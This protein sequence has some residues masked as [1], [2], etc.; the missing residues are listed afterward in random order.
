MQDSKGAYQRLVLNNVC[1]IIEKAMDLVYF[2]LLGSMHA[3]VL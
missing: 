2:F 3:A 1:V